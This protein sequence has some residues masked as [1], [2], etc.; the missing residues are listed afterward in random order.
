MCFESLFG[1]GDDKPKYQQQP[2]AA[3]ADP[4]K[5]RLKAENEATAKANAEA[6]VKR[7]SMRKSSLLAAG[8]RGDPTQLNSSDSAA[9]GKERLGA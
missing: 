3:A 1:G 7:K 5:E 9:A 8:A 6:A 2:A 4:E